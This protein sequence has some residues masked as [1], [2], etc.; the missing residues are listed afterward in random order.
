MKIEPL[1]RSNVRR[2]M[3]YCRDRG[4]A[5]ERQ[6]RA[7]EQWI[8][9]GRLYV[10]VARNGAQAIGFVIYFRIEKAPVEIDGEDVLAIQFMWVRPDRRGWG[11]GRLFDGQVCDD[12]AHLGRKGVIMERF[13][14][15]LVSGSAELMLR[16]YLS[17]GFRQLDHHWNNALFFMP[18]T[19]DAHTSQYSRSVF[20]PPAGKGCL[21][22]DML[23][24]DKFV[25]G[26]MDTEIVQRPLLPYAD[27]VEVRKHDQNLRENVLAR[28]RHFGIS[29]VDHFESFGA[30]I[31]EDHA[32]DTFER[33]LSP[34]STR[35]MSDAKHFTKG[36]Q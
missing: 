15:S 22:I 19:E 11:G 29:L 10:H 23:N 32:R 17:L 27:M 33:H 24:S 7:F 3:L 1:S 14:F 8:T 9:E 16:D 2:A 21:R 13:A 6:L 18:P 34:R 31:T 20:S 5:S 26:I 30:P 35:E 4:A 28:G 36:L 25:G 12:A